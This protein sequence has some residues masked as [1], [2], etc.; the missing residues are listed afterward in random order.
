[1]DKKISRIKTKIKSPIKDNKLVKQVIDL[2]N[3]NEEIHTLWEVTNVNALHRLKMTDHGP[4][5]FQVVTNHAIKMTRILRDANIEMTLTKDYGLDH[6]YAELVI[7]L[8]SLLHDLGM[9]INR[10][11][12]EEF[13]LILAN[14]LMREM[15]VFLPVYERTVVISEVLHA[16]INHRSGGKP[17]TL[18]AGIMRIADA[19]DMEKGRSRFANDAGNIDIHNISHFAIDKVDIL[20]GKNKP[21]LIK[22]TMNNSAGLFQVDELLNS[23]LTK[24]GIE[25][26]VEVSAYV[27]GKTEKKLIKDFLVK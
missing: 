8:A 14:T 2:I 22:I 17:L 10:S 12:H 6:E 1:M 15:L 3:N 11:G 13:S 26:L 7:V 5:H 19:L 23:K 4:V 21:I 27:T 9:S 16:I 20:K 18:E 25:H 24:S